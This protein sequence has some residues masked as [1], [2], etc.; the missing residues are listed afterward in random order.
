MPQ[1]VEGLGAGRP[2]DGTLGLR[3]LSVLSPALHSGLYS[4]LGAVGRGCGA[5]AESTVQACGQAADGAVSRWIT[6]SISVSSSCSSFVYRCTQYDDEVKNALA[7]ARAFVTQQAREVDNPAIVLDIDETS[8]SNWEQ[9]IH[10]DYGYVPSGAC[11][12]KAASAC[13]QRK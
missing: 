5:A 10:N 8:L 3:F 2:H 1:P 7:E 13:G 6:R 4:D 12:L 9:I 11:D